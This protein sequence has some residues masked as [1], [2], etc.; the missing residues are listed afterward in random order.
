LKQ[1]SSASTLTTLSIVGDPDDLIIRSKLDNQTVVSIEKGIAMA[2][3]KH[4]LLNQK[5][6]SASQV[7]I[8]ACMYLLIDYFHI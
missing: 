6:I 7:F 4:S 3:T 1:E 5:N 8:Y 2:K